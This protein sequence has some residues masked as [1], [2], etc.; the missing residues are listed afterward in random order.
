MTYT[1]AVIAALFMLGAAAADDQPKPPASAAE[2]LEAIKK[3]VKDAEEAFRK[4]YSEKPDAKPDDKKIEELYSAFTKKQTEGLTAAVEIAKSYPK[5]ETGFAALE[6]VLTNPRSYYLPPGETALKLAAENHAANPKIGKI[7]ALVGYIGPNEKSYPAAY[8]A[9]K[10]LITAVAEK[11][12]DKTARAQAHLALAYEK[13][14][15]FAAAEHAKAPDAEKLAAEAEQALEAVLKEHGDAPRLIREGSGTIGE[16]VKSELF[17]LR[18]LR[19]GK[20]APAIDGEDLEGVKF[21]LSDYRG[22]VVVLDF[23][24]DW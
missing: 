23:W 16:F 14:Q 12:P 17:E 21:K 8:A 20:T 13:R 10:K 11:N 4:A 18:N 2:K 22:K 9:A 1:R 5:S 6:W 24:G 3:G 15:K 19:I 7:V